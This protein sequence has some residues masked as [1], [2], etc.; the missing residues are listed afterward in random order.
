MTAPFVLS[1]SSVATFLRCGRQFWYAYVERR[2]DPPTVKQ[3]VGRA[4]HEAVETNYRQKLVTT[5]DLPTIDVLDA[6]TTA[7]D[8]EIPDVDTPEEDTGKA[9]DSG[10]AIT[11]L[12]QH[13]VA[14]GIQPEFVKEPVQFEV[15][16]IPYSGFLDLAAAGRVRDLKTT[17]RKPNADN[18][19]GIQLTGYALGY[20][21]KTG[22]KEAGVA[23][24]YLVRTKKP[25]YVPVES[26]PVSDA[27]IRSY[28]SVVQ[29][30]SD[31]IEAGTFLPNGLIGNPPACSWC[32]YKAIC[33]DYQGSAIKLLRTP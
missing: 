24:D 4:T 14:P 26:G 6:F 23:L 29:Q 1:A 32:G 2:R 21:Q 27:T 33:P 30:V 13:D 3:I 5:T 31:S 9:K 20:R 18:P 7:Y 17:T 16:G 12:Y 25:Q 11:R 15:N 28:A 19:Y 22:K 10:V 8:R